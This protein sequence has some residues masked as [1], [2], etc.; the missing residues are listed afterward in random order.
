MSFSKELLFRCNG[1][2]CH[3]LTTLSLTVTVL[4]SQV[5][6]AIALPFSLYT[7]FAWQEQWKCFALERT[8]FPIGKK[9]L[10]FLPCNMAALQNLYSHCFGNSAWF[11]LW[12]VVKHNKLNALCENL[13]FS[14]CGKIGSDFLMAIKTNLVR[15]YSTA[16]S[17]MHIGRGFHKVDARAVHEVCPCIH[18]GKN[19][20]STR[21]NRDKTQGILF[22]NNHVFVLLIAFV[23]VSIALYCSELDQN[24][25]EIVIRNV[26]ENTVRRIKSC[27]TA[28]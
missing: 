19:E 10:L 27:A 4:K 5:L 9:N 6:L 1:H 16:W 3:K 15:N 28:C 12:V 25:Q 21:R 7:G 17:H 14:K 13:H 11:Y 22:F 23:F 18:L 26:K 8:F 20:W 24:T 2:L